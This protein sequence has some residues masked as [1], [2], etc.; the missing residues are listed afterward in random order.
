MLTQCV[1]VRKFMK[2]LELNVRMIESNENSGVYILKRIDP[3]LL[4]RTV[5][6]LT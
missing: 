1:D 4:L 6:L 5:W 3:F 2:N